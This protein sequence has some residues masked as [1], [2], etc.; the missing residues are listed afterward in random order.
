MLKVSSRA[1]AGVHLPAAKM[2]ADA[3][4]TPKLI[5]QS[6]YGGFGDVSPSS[7][8]RRLLRKVHD[9]L[10]STFSLPILLVNASQVQAIGYQRK[11]DCFSFALFN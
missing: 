8:W 10:V 4:R 7:P 1:I 9:R 11:L 2:D 5:S 3:S 6:N